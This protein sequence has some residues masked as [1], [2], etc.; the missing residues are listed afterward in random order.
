[1]KESIRFEKMGV[2]FGVYGL[3]AENSK[4]AGFG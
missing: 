2:V 4:M 1:M 3:I